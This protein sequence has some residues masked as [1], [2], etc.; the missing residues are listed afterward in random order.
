MALCWRV[1]I[2]EGLRI[3]RMGEIVNLNKARKN[4]N[5]A[6]ERRK[7]AENRIRHGRTRAEKA[8]DRDQTARREHELDRSK[9]DQDG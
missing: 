4:H 3:P 2:Q 1:V 5:R 7:A 6:V 9:L 8:K